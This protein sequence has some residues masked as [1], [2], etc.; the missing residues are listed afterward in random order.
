MSTQVFDAMHSVFLNQL[1]VYIVVFSIVKL[2]QPQT[3]DQVAKK[4]TTDRASTDTDRP[5]WTLLMHKF[6]MGMS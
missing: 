5:L 2:L 4:Q 1:G 3:K 6:V